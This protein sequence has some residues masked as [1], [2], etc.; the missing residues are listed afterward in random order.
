[1]SPL[2]VKGDILCYLNINRFAVEYTTDTERVYSIMYLLPYGKNKINSEEEFFQLRYDSLADIFRRHIFTPNASLTEVLLPKELEPRPLVEFED[3]FKS[4]KEP[5]HTLLSNFNVD[6]LAKTRYDTIKSILGSKP[7]NMSFNDLLNDDFMEIDE[8]DGELEKDFIDDI[9]ESE[10]DKAHRIFKETY[11]DILEKYDV[12]RAVDVNGF[13]ENGYFTILPFIEKNKRVA[14]YDL[15]YE[16]IHKLNTE[17]KLRGARKKYCEYMRKSC[18]T[19]HKE[20]GYSGTLKDIENLYNFL[21]IPS[22]T[23]R[24]KR[25]NRVKAYEILK[26]RFEPEMCQSE[27]NVTM[28]MRSF[29]VQFFIDEHEKSCKN[30]ARWCEVE[31]KPFS[32]ICDL[33]KAGYYYFDGGKRSHELLQ[34]VIEI[35]LKKNSSA[36]KSCTD[37]SREC[38]KKIV[39]YLIGRVVTKYGILEEFKDEVVNIEFMTKVKE[40]VN[41]LKTCLRKVKAAYNKKSLQERK[42]S[43]KTS[44]EC[45]QKKHNILKDF[46]IGDPKVINT[47]FMKEVKKAVDM[48]TLH[49]NRI[50]IFCEDGLIFNPKLKVISTELDEET[51]SDEDTDETES[52]EEMKETGSY[53]DTNETESD[54]EMKKTGSD[55]DTDETGSDEDTDS[56]SAVPMDVDTEAEVDYNSPLAIMNALKPFCEQAGMDFDFNPT[57]TVDDLW[58]DFKD[59][60]RPIL[61]QLIAED[62][63]RTKTIKCCSQ[64]PENPDDLRLYL[65]QDDGTDWFETGPY[66]LTATDIKTT[67]EQY[68]RILSDSGLPVAS[69]IVPDD[70][71]TDDDII[72]RQ[73]YIKRLVPRMSRDDQQRFTRASQT[74]K[75]DSNAMYYK[76]LSGELEDE[77]QKLLN[78]AVRKATSNT[79]E[80]E[81]F[82]ADLEQWH[83]DNE[84]DVIKKLDGEKKDVIKLIRRFRIMNLLPDKY[85]NK[86]DEVLKMDEKEH[87]KVF[88]NLPDPEN[89]SDES[90]NESETDEESEV[91]MEDLAKEEL[92]AKITHIE[93]IFK[94][95]NINY[96]PNNRGNPKDDPAILYDYRGEIIDFKNVTWTPDLKKTIINL[97]PKRETTL[98]SFDKLSDDELLGELEAFYDK[99]NDL[100]IDMDYPICIDWDNVIH[101]WNELI[102]A[103]NESGEGDDIQNYIPFDKYVPDPD[104]FHEIQGTDEPRNTEYDA[105]DKTL[106]AEKK[107]EL[108]KL[109]RFYDDNL[110][111]FVEEL[112]KVLKEMA[113]IRTRAVKMYSSKKRTGD[114]LPGPPLKKAKIGE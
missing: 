15:V 51:G 101:K 58:E 60:K 75:S 74:T 3:K 87:R 104:L 25:K 91:L 113:S 107:K 77:R 50:G 8:S 70:C 6:E 105:W 112:Q 93:S 47:E 69:M 82:D 108:G 71:E 94:K 83:I 35:E 80:M 110:V 13:F 38:E 68:I 5:I 32:S 37:A 22:V 81:E 39:K 96:T 41:K 109:S 56:D 78:E 54:E 111:D 65:N 59:T 72:Y 33:Y 40:A 86:D 43:M 18:E 4:Y 17:T 106:T 21:T 55:E 20:V 23:S 19:L 46:N 85:D 9:V 102:K 24:M 30:M 66:P 27:S 114:S 76:Q 67:A 7:L 11:A 88:E 36:L 103:W 16:T 29:L 57:T 61:D 98:T 52:D 45:A 53:E 95:Y 28:L 34:E 42:D 2:V 48:L 44:I 89:T 64:L 62:P 26:N 99:Q 100:L 10:F 1:M 97:L 84:A 31:L 14:F 63:Y 79:N 90:E 12:K 73:L 92:I 49:L